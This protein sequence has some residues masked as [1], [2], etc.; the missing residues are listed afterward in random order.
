MIVATALTAQESSTIS[1]D[2]GVQVHIS[3]NFG[4]PTGQEALHVEMKRASG[5]SFYRVFRDQNNLVVYA[6]QL[7]LNAAGNGA[8][9]TAIAKAYDEQFTSRFPNADGGKPAPTLS[10]DRQLGPLAN[11]QSA[12]L[13]LFEIPGMGLH[14]VETLSVK[15]DQPGSGGALRFSGLEVSINGKPVSGSQQAEVSG[16]H[17]MF[18]VPGGGG[19]FFAAV[20][21]GH[22]FV[23]AGVVDGNRMRFSLDNENYECV[24]NKP[25]LTG[26]SSS[27]LWVLHDPGY[28]PDGNWTEHLRSGSST[29]PAAD[30]FF[31][32]ASDSLSWW[33]P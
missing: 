24:A 22:G 8:A 25:I 16:R 21:P 29:R 9:I 11:N 23:K 4:Q 26:A 19:Y 10:A 15:I 5:N 1:L 31:A 3:A 30:Q 32:A 20:D 17:V 18:Y 13:D 7:V 14:V 6:Y 12:N 2:N 28:Q 27:E 33:L